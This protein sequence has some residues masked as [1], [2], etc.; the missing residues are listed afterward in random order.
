[1]KVLNCQIKEIF[2]LKNFNY[3]KENFVFTES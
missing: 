1:M 2:N 3:N